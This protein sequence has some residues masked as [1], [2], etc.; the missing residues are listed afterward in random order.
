M[1]IIEAHFPNMSLSK[2]K[3]VIF[4]IVVIL[5]LSVFTADCYAKKLWDRSLFS[6]IYQ[7]EPVRYE[8]RLTIVAKNK[9]PIAL[10]LRYRGEEER[11][12]P[13]QE[14]ISVL[15]KKVGT[16]E[17][18]TVTDLRKATIEE[19][20][21]VLIHVSENAYWYLD[22]K[23]PRDSGLFKRT[24][25]IFDREI[26]PKMSELFGSLV[27]PS[28]SRDKRITVLNTP[29]NGVSGYFSSAD[30]YPRW[31]HPS[32]NERE[33]IF[34]DPQR[35]PV[36]TQQY[37]AVLAH[38][39][40]HAIHN[41]YDSGEESWVNEGLS[42]LAVELLGFENRFKEYHLKNPSIQLNF[43]S[44]NPSEAVKD[45]AASS[46]FFSFLINEN[47]ATTTLS[48]L[49]GE[50]EDGV[51]G[52]NKWLSQYDSNFDQE[53][54]KWIVNNYKEGVKEI[55]GPEYRR[56][57]RYEVP[58]YGAKYFDLERFRGRTISFVGDLWVQRFEAICPEICWWSNT[59]DYINTSLTLKADLSFAKKP[60]AKFRMWH[61]IEKDWDYL[62]FS[63][64]VD[65]GITWRTLEE[66]TKTTSYNP[67]GSNFGNGYTGKDGW[68]DHDVN[69][70]EYSGKEVLL[71]FEY[72]TDD[73]VNLGGVLI[74]R[75]EIVGTDVT[76]NPNSSGWI[77]EG[78]M[79]VNNVLPQKFIVRLVEF[80]FD[81]T[82]TIRKVKLDENNETSIDILKKDGSVK[83]VGLVVAGATLNTY[84]PTAFNLIY[85]N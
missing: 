77:P 20:D 23:L 45:Y 25:E 1:N 62:Y 47:G 76:L 17:K 2:W 69:L 21:A 29:L 59:G 46:S 41:Y 43:W 6:T 52:L 84:R 68:F 53:F 55:S 48:D 24:G 57:V 9:D 35:V 51:R 5:L 31:V 13:N 82:N 38:E 49:V 12:S 80:H 11:L 65:Q 78:F 22:V 4:P 85:A 66:E 37:L 19:V 14:S 75:F 61:D 63:V 67:S 81:G 44:S 16:V 15:P 40:Q 32:S 39:Y 72:V 18:F 42:E 71:R 56:N 70:S 26:H 64:S 3:P 83:K 8:E 34:M 7:N 36:G 79:L 50:Q 73:A 33:I 30:S 60:V 28:V 27:S 74:D 58:Q 10:A 54:T